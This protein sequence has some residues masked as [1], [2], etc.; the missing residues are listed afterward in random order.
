MT[1]ILFKSRGKL[2]RLSF[3][4]L[5]SFV[6]Q[7]SFSQVEEIIIED[8]QNSYS[9]S[10]APIDRN[11]L[12]SV[13]QGLYLAQDIQQNGYVNKLSFKIAGLENG[14]DVLKNI[15]I[16]L[17]LTS[18]NELYTG[19]YNHEGY[20][21]VYDGDLAI[22]N[23]DGYANF[24]LTAPFYYDNNSNLLISVEHNNQYQSG[25][26]VEWKESYYNALLS[27]SESSAEALPEY[28]YESSYRPDIKLTLGCMFIY[29]L[30]D[31]SICYGKSIK[32]GGEEVNYVGGNI[33]SYSWSPSNSLNSNTIIAPIA[34]PDTTTFYQLTLNVSG[35]EPQTA[36]MKL[37][38]NDGSISE[39]NIGDMRTVSLCGGRFFDSGGAQEGYSYNEDYTITIYPCDTLHLVK[40]TFEY[41]D[42]GESDWL[43]VYDGN[44]TN[45]NLIGIFNNENYLSGEILSSHSSGSLTFKFHSD[46]GTSGNGWDANVSCDDYNCKAVAGIANISDTGDGI[47]SGTAVLSLSGNE[48]TFSHW[49]KSFDKI[50]VEGMAGSTITQNVLNHTT[51][52]YRAVVA[53]KFKTCYSNFVKYS[54]SNNYYVN[55]TDTTHD[56]WSKGLGSS[57]NKGMCPDKPLNKIYTIIQ[58]YNLKS[59]DTIF[60][61]AGNYTDD[62]ILFTGYD[63]GSFNDT[64]QRIVLLGA[65]KSYCKINCD[66]ATS[67]SYGLE[68]NNL[69]VNGS[70]YGDHISNLLI[71]R[72]VLYSPWF[73][74]I[75]FSEN[76]D[77]ASYFIIRNSY[78]EASGDNIMLSSC[79]DNTIISG[80]IIT[81]KDIL[82]STSPI[83]CDIYKVTN[84]LN[85]NN[86]F[87]RSKDIGINLI[88]NSF[89]YNNLNISNN[90]IKV[91]DTILEGNSCLYVDGTD[92][93]SGNKTNIN[94]NYFI[95]SYNSMI[96]MNLKKTR[97]Y[98]NYI[99]N[100]PYGISLSSFAENVG[101]YNNSFNN[102]KGNIDFYSLSNSS[103]INIKNNILKNTSDIETDVCL[104]VT[105]SNIDNS[106]DLLTSCDNNLY[107]APNKA[108][109]ARFSANNFNSVEELKAFNHISGND[110]GDENSVYGDPFFI[111][112]DRGNLAVFESS[113]AIG[114]GTQI[115]DITTDIKYNTLSSPYS[116][117]AASMVMSIP[118]SPNGPYAELKRKLDGGYHLVKSPYLLIKYTEEYNPLYSKLKFKVYDKNRSVVMSSDVVNSN[119]INDI[120]I[121]TGDNYISIKLFGC[122]NCGFQSLAENEFYILEVN[123]DKNEKWYLRFK[124]EFTFDIFTQQMMCLCAVNQFQNFNSIFNSGE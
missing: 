93:S 9:S 107:F 45:C 115:E 81:S 124:P 6:F 17:S 53:D 102:S 51:T 112:A 82:S 20:T 19:N 117:G 13:W 68:F 76:I 99:S 44:N 56:K 18:D 88:S 91:N 79:I 69:N 90:I 54:S 8:D 3:L 39:V 4:F 74:N 50:D 72:S 95:G 64:T 97:I 84:N 37:F 5:F 113:P 61:D 36:D 14:S 1:N 57:E 40:T 96:L 28:L 101:V 104:R 15:K 77:S 55:D 78:L 12:F 121:N 110:I 24:I 42:L 29:P 22:N 46:F 49:E 11:N 94:N 86:N 116:I 48:G 73:N 32:L 98:N 52:Y 75:T 103:D 60:I 35:C 25:S 31:K 7:S 21:L 62:Y 100:S 119:I 108:K 109:V 70:I 118:G 67:Y 30:T 33:L 83:L 89:A 85:I 34:N 80:N 111:E 120:P 16:Y 27:R 43:A 38:V 47:H 58:N 106:L 41:F 123:N 66:I 63:H 122:K 105:N 92:A 71:E 23:E 59:G 114:K 26:P 65:N 2:I 10:S 87:I